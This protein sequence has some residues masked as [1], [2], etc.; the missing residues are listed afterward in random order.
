MRELVGRVTRFGSGAGRSVVR[1]AAG[2]TGGSVSL[3]RTGKGQV[4]QGRRT[5]PS[6]VSWTGRPRGFKRGRGPEAALVNWLFWLCVGIRLWDGSQSVQITQSQVALKAAGVFVV[7]VGGWGTAR[8][9]MRQDTQL[10]D[11][12]PPEMG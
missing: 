1:M 8:C 11:D 10:H 9:E 3:G 7:V 5:L 2:M 4:R 6:M 12:A